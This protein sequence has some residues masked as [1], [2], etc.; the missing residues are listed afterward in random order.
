MTKKVLPKEASEFTKKVNEK[1]KKLYH[2]RTRKI[3]KMQRKALLAL[4]IM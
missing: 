3:L 4:G 1:V 2:L